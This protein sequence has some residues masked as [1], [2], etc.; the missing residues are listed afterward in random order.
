[1]VRTNESISKIVHNA[2]YIMNIRWILIIIGMYLCFSVAY[3]VDYTFV[4]TLL[5][6][7]S[8]HS[9][10]AVFNV[11]FDYNSI[12]YRSIEK[13]ALNL[14]LCQE[15]RMNLKIVFWSAVFAHVFEAYL[16]YS[17]TKRLAMKL[18]VTAAWTLQTLILGYPSLSLLLHREKMLQQSSK[19]QM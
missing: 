18:D 12:L 5:S 11:V 1:M 2:G 7:G 13:F 3:D 10:L 16:A 14:F 15:S 6:K 9:Q 19:K 4:Q 8:L 17:T